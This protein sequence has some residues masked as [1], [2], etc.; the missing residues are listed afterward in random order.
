MSVSRPLHIYGLVRFYPDLREPNQN[1]WNE[2][3]G[4]LAEQV[5][6]RMDADEDAFGY[7]IVVVPSPAMRSGRW[8]S[9]YNT[10]TRCLVCCETFHESGGLY[11]PGETTTMAHAAKEFGMGKLLELVRENHPEMIESV[12]R[13]SNIDFYAIGRA[14]E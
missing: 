4:I 5:L 12:N 1:E 2:D 8:D 14:S 3:H 13:P 6:Q 10:A 9:M 7:Q 11:G